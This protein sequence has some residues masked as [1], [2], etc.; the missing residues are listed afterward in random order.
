MALATCNQPSNAQIY[1]ICSEA[2]GGK[3][4]LADTFPKAYFLNIEGATNTKS[5]R[6][7]TKPPSTGK[8]ITDAIRDF[9]TE[10]H[11]YKHLVFDS[12]TQIERIYQS[13][14][15]ATENG[16]P[17]VECCGGYGKSYEM[18]HQRMREFAEVCRRLRDEKGYNV[19]WIFHATARE[20]ELPGSPAFQRW[21][22]SLWY[23][24]DGTKDNN[25][26]FQSL[27]DNWFHIRLDYETLSDGSDS[28]SKVEG[29]II[30]RKVGVQAPLSRRV[31]TQPTTTYFAKNRLDL[32]GEVPFV[33]NQTPSFLRKDE[34]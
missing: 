28:G 33:F 34:K 32:Q 29:D 12:V 20:M 4:S 25:L 10:K 31:G 3:T 19:V 11:D 14:I 30:R 27:A 21:V 23:G 22:P 18:L 1:A 8:E 16:K 15:V 26:I 24:K 6:H 13:D 5:I 17:F 9:A 2:G 7:W